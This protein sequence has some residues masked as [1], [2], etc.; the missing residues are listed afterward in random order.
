M[1]IGILDIKGALPCFENF[2]NLPTV[3]VNEDNIH[4]VKDLDMLIIP[5]GSLIESLSLNEPLKKHLLEFDGILFGVCSGFQVLSKKI[6]IGRKS[7][8]PIFREGLGLLDVEFSPLICTDR[9]EFKL[10]DNS[11]FG[12]PG[13][14][15]E[16]FHCHTYG[17]IKIGKDVKLLTV[18][19]VRKL[20]YRFL[21]EEGHIV[22]GVYRKNVYGTMVHGFLDNEH[23]KRHLLESLGVD[24]EE[25]RTILTKNKDLREKLKKKSVIYS[26]RRG[27]RRREDRGKR[28]MILLSTGSNCGKTFLL[29]SIVSKL[30]GRTFV[31]KIGPDVRDIVPSLYIL[32][33]PML[34]Y[35]SIKIGER[36]WCSVE[37]FLKFVK[38]SDYNYYIVEG[39]MGAFT[40]ALREKNYSSAEVSKLLGFPVYLISS[41]SK[42]GIE[43][44]FVEGL[45]YY[46][47][48]KS[49]GVDVRGIILNKVYNVQLFE[50]VRRIGEEIGVKVIGVKKIEDG[51]RRGFIPEVEIDYESFC[52]RAME[53]DVKVE[54]PP[55]EIERREEDSNNFEYYLRRWAS[56][57]FRSLI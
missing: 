48:L 28:G 8:Y 31:A 6:D 54:I 44:A 9:V 17:N 22:S 49:I 38:R 13:D 29:T 33:E 14:R 2:G 10:M 30:D 23:I 1:E 11:I 57:L 47:L 16:G 5:G 4:I 37:E 51:D 12:R 7:Y 42:G 46:S 20:N 56:K 32:R 41:C 19:K 45:S 21:E 34:K 53:L 24:Q 27:Y 43:G 39:V 35:S 18:S 36:G 55:I 3:A 25:Y 26:N 15:G 50:K 40:G 52:R